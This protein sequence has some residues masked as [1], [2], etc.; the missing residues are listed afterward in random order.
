MDPTDDIQKVFEKPRIGK[1]FGVIDD[2]DERPDD[3]RTND[4]I[5]GKR[6]DDTQ[7]SVDQEISEAQALG[8]AGDQKSAQRE[9]HRNKSVFREPEYR[10]PDEV[11]VPG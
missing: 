6:R 9:E 11:I 2:R 7:A 5:D 4:D 8:A 3:Q 10:P 1:I